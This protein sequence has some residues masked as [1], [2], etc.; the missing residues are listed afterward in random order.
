MIVRGGGKK[1]EEIELFFHTLKTHLEKERKA[2][3]FVDE[4]GRD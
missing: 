2:L 1:M 3:V 4:G